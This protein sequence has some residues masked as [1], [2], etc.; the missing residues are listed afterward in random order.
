MP[1]EYIHPIQGNIP[2]THTLHGR[3]LDAKR[4]LNNRVGYDEAMRRTFGE[5]YKNNE[6]VSREMK[7][8]MGE[9]KVE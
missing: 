9:E 3:L 8:F 7:D 1:E 4:L 5:H 6:R 2:S